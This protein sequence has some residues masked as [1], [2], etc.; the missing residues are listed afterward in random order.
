MDSENTTIVYLREFFNDPKYKI[1][2]FYN[3]YYINNGD[4]PCIKLKFIDDDKIIYISALEKCS[5]ELNIGS[6]KK[7]VE[8]V[9]EIAKDKG[10]AIELI[11]D[12]YIG[13]DNIGTD[14]I[15]LKYLFLLTKGETWYNS[16]GLKEVNYDENSVTMKRFID[17]SISI[18]LDEGEYL[19]E[20]SFSTKKF[21][22][23]KLLLEKHHKLDTPIKKIF[24]DLKSHS[25]KNKLSDYE[26]S[27]I[28]IF[29]MND[30][31]EHNKTINE[32]IK[33]KTY[34]VTPK[35]KKDSTSGGKR[36]KKS[37]YIRKGKKGKK[38]I[39]KRK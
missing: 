39:K 28:Y 33:Q 15:S 26:N 3:C 14:Y 16:I 37:K 30:T 31:L 35:F 20:N 9:I 36:K 23:I 6:G 29:L 10:Y 17:S 25:K 32:I 5:D 12:S 21:D 2:Y 11:D 13:T 19:P 7:L 4:E 38:S 8:T 1:K 34:L 18:L 22:K 24:N 27:L